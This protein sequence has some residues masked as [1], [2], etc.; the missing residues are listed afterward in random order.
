[1]NG[2]RQGRVINSFALSLPITRSAL[3]AK[4]NVGPMERLGFSALDRRSAFPPAV[5]DV[6]AGA[7]VAGQAA[8]LENEQGIAVIKDGHLRIGRFAIVHVTK[9]AANAEDLRGQF[10][11]AEGPAAFVHFV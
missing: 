10:R 4:L 8:H 1:M 2:G 3:G 9:T 11:L 7:A 5:F 6:R